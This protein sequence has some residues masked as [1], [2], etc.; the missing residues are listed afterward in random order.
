MVRK[1]YP[2]S[3]TV[4]IGAVVADNERL[5][6][7]TAPSSGSLTATIA[8]SASEYAFAWV[9]P[10]NE[11]GYAAWDDWVNDGDDYFIVLDVTAIG[12]SLSLRT[13][14]FGPTAFTSDLSAITGTQPGSDWSSTTGTGVK[15]SRETSS[16]TWSSGATTRF[17]ARVYVRHDGT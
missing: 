5:A 17:G 1:F 13:V 3:T 4:S 10:A 7:E 14:L 8:V 16:G 12:A 11:P 15:T 2:T 9:T 6:S